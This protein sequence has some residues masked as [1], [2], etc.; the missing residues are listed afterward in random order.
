MTLIAP[1]AVPELRQLA[2]EGSISWEQRVYEGP[3]DLEGVFMAIAATNDACKRL[4]A[5]PGVGPLVATALVAAVA[6]GTGFKGPQPSEI[7]DRDWRADPSDGMRPVRH[8]RLSYKGEA[9]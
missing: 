1:E 3:A 2:D 6:D 8:V 9:A 5:I 4:L 7:A